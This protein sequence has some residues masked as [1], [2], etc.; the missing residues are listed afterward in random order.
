MWED[1]LRNRIN[2]IYGDKY[3]TERFLIEL[4]HMVMETKKSH[5]D[6]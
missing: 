5:C 2:R 4:A 3:V 1:S 6:L